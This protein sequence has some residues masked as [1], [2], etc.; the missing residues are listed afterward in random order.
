MVSE[1]WTPATSPA[2]HAATEI[3]VRAPV[4]H[5]A[6][7]LESFIAPES[8]VACDAAHENVAAVSRMAHDHGG[9]RLLP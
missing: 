4:P 1:S 2:P 7:P 6:F 3:D 5:H 8:L 9:S